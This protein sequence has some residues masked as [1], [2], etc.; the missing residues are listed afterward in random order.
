MKPIRRLLTVVIFLLSVVAFPISVL[1]LI[2]I[3]YLFTGRTN[4]MEI[5][6]NTLDELM[7]RINPD[8]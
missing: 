6:T 8:K 3:Q 1:L 7:D 5:V 2:P 4:I